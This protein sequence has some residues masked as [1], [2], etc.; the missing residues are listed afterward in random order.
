MTSRGATTTLHHASSSNATPLVASGVR[1]LRY[2]PD[3]PNINHYYCYDDVVA[4]VVGL[5]AT[6][7]A[8]D[9][10]FATYSHGS[11]DSTCKIGDATISPF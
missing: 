11:R 10:C 8:R 3:S 6:C 2:G 9:S 1:T 5:V 7:E 4:V